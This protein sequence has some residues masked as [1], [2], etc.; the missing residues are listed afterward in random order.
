MAFDN[1]KLKRI[2]PQNSDAPVLWS[3]HSG[4][5]ALTEV[6]TSGYFNKA[7][8]RLQVGDILFVKPT[9]GAPGIMWVSGNT[10]DLSASPPVEGVVDVNDATGLNASDAD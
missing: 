7:A 9:T 4:A 1:A 3:Y 5:D 6:D 2:G 8:D 10:R